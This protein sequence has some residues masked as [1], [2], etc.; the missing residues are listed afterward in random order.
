VQIRSLD[1]LDLPL[2]GRVADAAE[3]EGFGFVRR[4]LDEAAS[5][6]VELDAPREFFLGAFAEMDL[7]ALGG[8]TPDPYLPLAHVGRMR[9]VYVTEAWRRRGI[10]R[11]LVQALEHRVPDS[12]RL[13]RLRTLT[14]AGSAFY[15][16]LGYQPV[17]DPTATHIRWLRP[18]P[19]D[20]DA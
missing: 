3:R 12:C 8:I 13:L 18:G 10:G 7:V 6:A 14:A 11:A 20:P 9:H 15:E 5:G 16:R 4:F 1:R 2:V 17:Q 19:G